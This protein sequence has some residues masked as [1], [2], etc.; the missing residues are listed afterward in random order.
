MKVSDAIV[1]Y[2]ETK[3]ITHV[4][5]YPGGAVLPL[6]ESLRT[7][8]IEHV[9]VRNEQSAA[10][11]ASGY[12]RAKK[13]TGV[14]IATSGPGATNLITGI[15]TAYMDSIPMVII[16]GQVSTPM[17]G[18]DSFQEADI[19]GATEPFTKHNYLV[20]DP[21]QMIPILQE[22]FYI[23]STG[24][25]GPV[26]IDIPRDIFDAHTT[27]RVPKEPQILGYKPT[28][29]GHDG[30]LKKIVQSLK[31]AKRPLIYAG[32]GIIQSNAEELLCEFSKK[33]NVPVVNT[34]MGIGA[35]PMD[36]ELY[37]GM[38]GFHGNK[39]AQ[40]VL[41]KSDLVLI[42]GARMS[43]RATLNFKAIA[44][45][46]DVV[47]IDIDPAEIGKIVEHHIPVVGDAYAIL[48]KLMDKTPVLSQSK[49]L[50]EISEMKVPNTVIT[51]EAS[52]T[53]NP[54]TALRVLSR[55][56]EE[57]AIM[58]ADVGQ[59][60]IW[61]AKN[62]EFLGTRRFFTSGGLGTMG[63]SL[64]AGIGAK[65]GTPAKQVISVMGDGSFQMFM[66]ELGTLSELELPMMVL[67]FNNNRLGMV[68]E[69]QDKAY[70]KGKTFGVDFT[71]NPDFI[72]IASAYDIKSYRITSNDMLEET[73]K[74][75]LSE[76]GPVFVE[77]VVDSE[78]DTL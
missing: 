26:L 25:P 71:K 55:I 44:P 54:K 28:T 59:N 7:S 73:F 16:T 52:K 76:K 72:K 69:L 48:K 34:L 35:M 2:L 62:F 67:V 78:F 22:A 39:L 12:S 32:G 70:G 49:W 5:G 8:T 6:Y 57:S 29:Q 24:R 38:V 64:S 43:D 66:S 61:A 65:I 42:V 10:H 75:A 53:V 19:T 77:C 30:Q 17:I 63:Y 50:K 13:T 31:K 37:V 68:R 1:Q 14:C 21:N 4:F 40:A 46:T 47:H 36:S 60:Q 51:L 9:L 74:K 11:M 41:N 3:D 27:Y 56:A 33:T 45:T 58:T 15:A 20:K 23:A 18:K